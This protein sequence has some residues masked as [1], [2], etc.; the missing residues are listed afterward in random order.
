MENL[1]LHAT[2][3]S[4]SIHF[5][6]QS[7]TM[8]IKGKSYPENTSKFFAPVLEWL[9]Q[10]LEFS[11]KRPIVVELELTYLNSSSSKAFMNLFQLLERATR[12]GKEIVVNWHY[13]EENETA[14]ECGEEFREDLDGVTFNL[15]CIPTVDDPTNPA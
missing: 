12:N 6:A 11:D 5:D 15:V 1:V 2:K 8:E 7:G 3:S 4:P 9:G 10:Y 13:H 14:L